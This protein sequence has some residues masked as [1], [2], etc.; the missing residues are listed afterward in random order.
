MFEG[1]TF[2]PLN[3]CGLEPSYCS[4]EGSE[5][6]IIPAPYDLTTSYISGTR[7]G[8]LAIIE[9]STHMELFDEELGIETYKVG[10]H[11]L[12]FLEPTTSGPKEMVDRVAEVCDH[13]IRKG[14]IPVLLGGEHSLSFGMVRAIKSH[15]PDLS[16]LHLDAHADMKD[17]YNDSPF[18]H[19]CVSR[20]ISELCPV[21]Q[22][23][24]RSLSAEEAEFLRSSS[25][26]TIYADQFFTSSFDRRI[27]DSLTE[28]LY[29]TIDLDVFDPSIMPSVGTP[30]PG[31]LGWYDVLGIVK[32]V[33]RGRRVMGFDVVEL[34][35]IPGCIAPDFMAAKLVYRIMGYIIQERKRREEG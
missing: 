19:G 3:F 6:V 29:I 2:T 26:N 28:D 33:I 27:F 8:P 4:L 25:V 22:V 30:E 35:P 20:R 34:S 7:R 31:G 15:Y 1:L 32:E 10:I 17:V 21:V 23:G 16:I 12:P 9:A 11:T 5:F 14:K 18:N 24:I 13:I